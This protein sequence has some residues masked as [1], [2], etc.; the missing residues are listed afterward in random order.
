MNSDSFGI[1]LILIAIVVVLI[2]L[3]PNYLMGGNLEA[4]V[5]T[6]AITAIIGFSQMIVMS[7]GGMNVAIGSIGGITA[8]LSGSM[9][10]WHGQPILLTIIT[11]LLVGGV[12]GL[13]NG[14]ITY[15]LGG[16]GVAS[17]LATL[18]TSY[19]FY[20]VTLT[21][22]QGHP[23]YGIPELFILLGSGTSL[24]FSNTLYIMI[25]F[26]VALWFMYRY[27]GIGKQMLAFGGNERAAQL[28]GVRMFNVVITA[29][30]MSGVLAAIAGMLTVMK[31]QAAQT[32]IGQDWMLM[33]MA[34]PLLGGT[35][36]TGGK[37]NVAGAIIGSMILSV[38]ANALV[39]MRVDVYW[40]DFTNGLV[41]LI[42]AG[43]DVIRVRRRRKMGLL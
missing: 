4:L 24:F 27:T 32:A 13:I 3:K 8:V 29:H 40:N 5:R 26:A 38:I 20:G 43:I 28:Y 11:M 25:V 31:L 2:I 17:F 18:A 1:A 10:S 35:R 34:A 6:T 41:I 33:S 14:F 22:T 7:V 19:V 12:C 30:I 21:I 36:I 37:V 42:V 39:H 15:K 9:M 23:I 16:V